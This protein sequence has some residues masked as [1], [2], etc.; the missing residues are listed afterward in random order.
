M[1]IN[2]RLLKAAAI[3]SSKES[4]RY[5]LNGV[6]VQ[7][8]DDGSFLIATDGHRLIA[9]RQSQESSGE[10]VNII[11]PNDIVA[12]IKLNKHVETAELTR[13]SA[14]HWRLDYTGTSIIFAPIDGIFPD[15]KRIVP[16][17]ATGETA[18]YNPAYIGDFAKVSK[19]LSNRATAFAYNG[20]GPALVTFGEDIDGFGLLMPMRSRCDMQTAA[21]SWAV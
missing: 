11:I 2:I 9:F 6:A 8:S 5:Y 15:W 12:G 16:K 20:N 13:E 10:S 19:I 17:E 14:T 21:P 1:E 4:T 3:A 18:Q 7:S